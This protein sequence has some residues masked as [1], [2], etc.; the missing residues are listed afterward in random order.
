MQTVFAKQADWI[1][2]EPIPPLKE[3]AKQFGFTDASF[4]QCMANQKLLDD[5]QAVRDHAAQK[6]EVEF[7]PEFF[8]HRGRCQS[9][10]HRLIAS[11]NTRIMALRFEGHHPFIVAAAVTNRGRA[12]TRRRR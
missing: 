3:I 9:R 4:N 1:V 6:F 2:K 12:K 10:T 5:I 8:R 11:A 7:Y